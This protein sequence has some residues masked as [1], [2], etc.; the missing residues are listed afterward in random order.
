VAE[1]IELEFRESHKSPLSIWKYPEPGKRYII[2]ADV[3]MG[4]MKGDFSCGEVL[5]QD[6]EQVAEW[7][8]HIEPEVF[9]EEL[10]KLGIYYNEAIIGVE[11]N[12]HGLTVLTEL[13]RLLYS[14]IYYRYEID[15]KDNK[16][17]RQ[18]G[19]LTNSKSKPLMIDN[20]AKVLRE[21]DVI[22][23]GADL[24]LECQTYIDDGEMHASEGNFD[25]RVI[26]FSIA[27][28]I[29]KQMPIINTSGLIPAY[30]PSSVW[31]GY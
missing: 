15:K 22:I 20:F 24:L 7:H 3:A 27:L 13:K 29:Y 16:R 28:M 5:S 9:A 6:F 26:A 11:A 10:R 14:R 4:F 8:G 18:M 25:D 17:T 2:G 23:N 30:R 21:G 31:T 1:R 19:W 12:N